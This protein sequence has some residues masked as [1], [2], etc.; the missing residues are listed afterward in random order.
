MKDQKVIATIQEHYSGPLP[1]PADLEK[2]DQI[3]PG[4]AER[5]L[6]MAEKEQADRHKE[7]ER[8]SH[9]M[10]ALSLRGQWIGFF[11]AILFTGVSVFFAINGFEKLSALFGTPLIIWVCS[12]FVLHKTPKERQQP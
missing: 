10:C 3:V 2:Y 1:Q 5:I 6:A 11:L 8:Q 4:A 9:L 7:S 12:I